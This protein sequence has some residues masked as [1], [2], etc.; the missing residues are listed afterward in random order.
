MLSIAKPVFNSD[1]T[2]CRVQLAASFALMQCNNGRYLAAGTP[3]VVIEGRVPDVMSPPEGHCGQGWA[4]EP[5]W[6][7]WVPTGAVEGALIALA[8]RQHLRITTSW[9]KSQAEYIVSMEL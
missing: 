9:A 2:V 5:E 8:K 6:E 1:G 7:P 4:P 3:V